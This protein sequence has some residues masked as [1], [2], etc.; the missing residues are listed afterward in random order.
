[1]QSKKVTNLTAGQAMKELAK[2]LCG[3]HGLLL[4]YGPPWYTREMDDRLRK[5]LAK[6]GSSLQ[7]SHKS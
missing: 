2:V 5:A 4:S 3:L 6:A 1:M 7:S